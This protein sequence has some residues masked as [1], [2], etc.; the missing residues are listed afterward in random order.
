MVTSCMTSGIVAPAL[1]R[2]KGCEIRS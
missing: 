2:Y 1:L